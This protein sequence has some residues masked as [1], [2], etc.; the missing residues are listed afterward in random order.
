MKFLISI[1]V[2]VVLAG[3]CDG[4]E[5]FA[6]TVGVA[7]STGAGRACVAI[8]DPNLKPKQS[9][10][11]VLLDVPQSILNGTI[12]RKT[13]NSCSSLINVFD[14]ASFY[15][16]KIRKTDEVFV[17]VAVVNTRPASVWKGKVGIDLNH[18][19]KK[20]FFRKCLGSEGVHITAWRGKPLW[21]K[22]IWHA[23]YYLGYDTESDC[24]KRDYEGTN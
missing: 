24:K 11:I 3:Y 21:G 10:K 4:Q 16:V 15:L 20:E 6:R 23:Y 19:G 9:I 2:S 18:D 1:A 12:L 22:R 14:S 13:N 5:P 17:A 7:N 8:R